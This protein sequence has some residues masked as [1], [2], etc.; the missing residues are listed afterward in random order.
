MY[1]LLY[2]FKVKVLRCIPEVLL[3]NVVLG[4]Y[5]GDPDA[6]PEDDASKGYLDD[7]TVPKGYLVSY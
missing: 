6:S 3:E 5:I 4:Q 2:I 7:P 1:D